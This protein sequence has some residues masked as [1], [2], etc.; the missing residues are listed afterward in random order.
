MEILRYNYKT[1]EDK[2]YKGRVN[3][4]HQYEFGI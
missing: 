1:Q 4:K 2:F 3:F